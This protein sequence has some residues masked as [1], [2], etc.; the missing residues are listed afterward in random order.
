MS[1]I[2]ALPYALLI[3]FISAAAQ[4]SDTYIWKPNEVLR[5][6]FS[7]TIAIEEET[8]ADEICNDRP[9]ILLAPSVDVIEFK[10]LPD[11]AP[12]G[13]HSLGIP[14]KLMTCKQGEKLTVTGVKEDEHHAKWASVQTA[15]GVGGFI[16]GT[17]KMRDTREFVF[18]AI[19]I[20]EVK[21]R[22]PNG[23]FAVLHF[24]S[25]HIVMPESYWFA[26]V[27]DD[28]AVQKDRAKAILHAMEGAIKLARWNV[29]LDTTGIVHIDARVPKGLDDWLKET[30]HAAFWRGK[31]RKLWVDIVEKKLGLAAVGDD[32]ELLLAL[33]GAPVVG[34][35]GMEKVRPYRSASEMVSNQNLK[36]E[37]RIHRILP[38]NAG[39]PFALP[40]IGPPDDRDPKMPNI[41]MTLKPPIQ[42]PITEADPRGS[43]PQV[44]VAVFDSRMGM[45]DYLN[46][47]YSFDTEYTCDEDKRRK[48]K[49]DQKVSVKYALKRLAP[50]I[51][52]RI[53]QAIE[54]PLKVK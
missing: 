47:A 17:T 13:T 36:S 44:G 53:E 6:D 24:D 20:V 52:G 46:E 15:A 8:S 45:L 41:F 29:I 32:R 5:F 19:L 37:Y 33:T 42:G 21:N 54:A 22:T 2:R 18:E 9:A 25:A 39:Q 3:V 10:A 11:D 26:A 50:P 51:A 40:Y 7:K 35:D 30:E 4:G 27:A 1:L 48:Y 28:P 31:F 23:T 43:G 38:P 12:T 34:S 49:V 16:P 14:S